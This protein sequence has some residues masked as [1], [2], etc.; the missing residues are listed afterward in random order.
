[1][2]VIPFAIVGT[3]S[4]ARNYLDVARLCP[5]RFTA[6]GLV[7]RG[8]PAVEREY[9]VKTYATIHDLLAATSPRFVVT[10]LPWEVNPGAITTLV[11]QGMPV[12][13]ETPPAPNPT[14]MRELF[15]V[16]HAHQGN[17]QIAEQ[18]HL[19]PLHQAQIALARSGRL[20]NRA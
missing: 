16:V 2:R 10:S 15:A 5:E 17:V 13:S 19:R 18:L 1:M 6:V 9:G 3:G 7:S 11:A 8:N 4:R 20:G 12:L 14:A